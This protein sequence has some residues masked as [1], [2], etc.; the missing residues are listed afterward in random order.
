MR[1]TSW[2]RNFQEVQYHLNKMKGFTVMGDLDG[3]SKS[4]VPTFRET[5]GDLDNF[6]LKDNEFWQ[7]WLKNSNPILKDVRREGVAKYQILNSDCPVNLKK[8]FCMGEIQ[9]IS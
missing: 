9:I 4:V 1:A 5:K 7:I 3:Q 8:A 6:F 2:F